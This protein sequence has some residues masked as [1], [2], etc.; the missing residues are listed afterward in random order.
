VLKSQKSINNKMSITKNDY[1]KQIIVYY[2]KYTK[3]MID[4]SNEDEYNIIGNRS[5]ITIF[6]TVFIKI[7]RVNLSDFLF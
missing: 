5:I 4:R 7:I 2:P 6:T 3:K 1:I